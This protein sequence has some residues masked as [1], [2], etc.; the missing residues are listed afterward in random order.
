MNEEE[1]DPLGDLSPTSYLAAQCAYHYR[2]GGAEAL[3]LL[4]ANMIHPSEGFLKAIANDPAFSE[5]DR[6][7]I[8]GASQVTKQDL[9]AAA[10]ELRQMDLSP[11]A[12][13]LDQI[14]PEAPCRDLMEVKAILSE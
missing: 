13:V 3:R 2:K 11:I 14:A 1:L 8:S 9:Q 7:T 5:A 4:L 10:T 6:K 12:A